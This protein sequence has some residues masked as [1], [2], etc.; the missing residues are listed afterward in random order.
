M[1]DNNI[2]KNDFSDQL[3][4]KIKKEKVKQVPKNIF[5]IKNIFIWI[6]LVL[7]IFV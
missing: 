1:K 4:K 6:F 5:V 7:S 3:L 2:L